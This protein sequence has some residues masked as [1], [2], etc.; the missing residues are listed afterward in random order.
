MNGLNQIKSQN[1]AAAR[2]HR[3]KYKAQLLA[4]GKTTL[5]KLDQLGQVDIDV[6]PL[7]FDS[8]DAAKGHLN[9]TIPL[10]LQSSYLISTPPQA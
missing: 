6:L 8:Y 1:E 3:A 4:Q 10:H 2:D 9:K 5:C 7:S